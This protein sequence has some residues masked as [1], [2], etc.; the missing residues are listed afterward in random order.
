[1]GQNCFWPI[2]PAHRQNWRS[3]LWQNWQFPHYP[4]SETSSPWCSK[5]LLLFQ[6]PLQH[7][8]YPVEPYPCSLS[9]TLWS[10]KDF[11]QPAMDELS[12]DGSS[13][14]TQ[15]SA[16]PDNPLTPAPANM[17]WPY[18]YYATPAGYYFASPSTPS[19][20]SHP[21]PVPHQFIYQPTYPP[22]PAL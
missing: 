22:N 3:P 8:L 11:L 12:N 19:H 1:M 18:A 6:P 21:S 14:S 2:V 20:F 10:C 13:P 17:L 5:N 9:L 4:T 15:A 7:P 16:F